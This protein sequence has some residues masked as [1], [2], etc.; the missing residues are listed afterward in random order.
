VEKNNHPSCLS[1]G[2]PAVLK[3]DL[4]TT[5][6]RTFSNPAGEPKSGTIWII[7]IFRGLEAIY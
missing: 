2:P 6:M 1:F 3:K 4:Y 7:I 5:S